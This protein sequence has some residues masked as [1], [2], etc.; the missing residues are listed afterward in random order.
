MKRLPHAAA[1]FQRVGAA[2]KGAIEVAMNLVFSLTTL[3]KQSQLEQSPNIRP[4]TSQRDKNRNVGGIILGVLTVR[5]KVDSPLVTTD[6]EI[7]TSDVLPHP[8]PLR[9]RV[10][11]DHESVRAIHRLRHGARARL[12]R[13]RTASVRLSGA[14]GDNSRWLRH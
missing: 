10:P 7:V 11:L 9:Q 12:Q 1:V 2:L 4:F 13:Q 6:G 3:I 5:V 8:H 14:G